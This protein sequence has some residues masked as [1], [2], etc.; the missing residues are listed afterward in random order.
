M[1]A[2]GRS[3]SSEHCRPS[4][5]A[6]TFAST[7]QIHSLTFPFLSPSEISHHRYFP[8]RP[9]QAFVIAVPVSS[10]TPPAG[11]RPPR[12]RDAREHT[13]PPASPPPGHRSTGDPL[14][15]SPL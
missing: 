3:P 10:L 6:N 11:H 8:N 5:R 4:P 12:T 7:R 9:G 2:V 13:L 1:P 15:L 14:S